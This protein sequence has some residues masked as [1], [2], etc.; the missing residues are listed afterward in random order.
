MDQKDLTLMTFAPRVY[1]L[2]IDFDGHCDFFKLARILQR[3]L[4]L[5]WI[6]IKVKYYPKDLDLSSI[7]QLSPFFTALNFGD[8]NKETGKPLIVAKWPS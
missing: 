3:C 4:I 7:R 2:Q 6:Q 5:E 1:R 8:V